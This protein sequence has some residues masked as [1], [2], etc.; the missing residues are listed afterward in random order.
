MVGK[1]IYSEEYIQSICS[2]WSQSFGGDGY[3]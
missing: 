2:S 3:D 1:A